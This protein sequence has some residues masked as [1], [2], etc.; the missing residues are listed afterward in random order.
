MNQ[1]LT[2]E[3][4]LETEFKIDFNGYNALEVDS[5]LDKVLQDYAAFE[6]QITEQLEL[7]ERY[8]TTLEKQKRIIQE[9]HNAE[10]VSKDVEPLP[11]YVDLLRRIA[12]LEAAVFSE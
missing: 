4:I 6:K 7:L 8:E 1:K 11:S 12:K 5:F 2:A 9:F 3:E 10:R